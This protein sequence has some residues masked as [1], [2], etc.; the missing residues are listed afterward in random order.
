[1]ALQKEIVLKNGVTTNYHRIV[2]L[3]LITNWSIIIEVRSYVSKDGREIEQRYEELQKK[4][5]K[6]EEL[7]L[8]EQKIYNEGAHCFM[9]SEYFETEYN[10]NTSISALYQYLKTLDKFQDAIDV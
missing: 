7:T 9:Y 6:G 4:M 5:L 1:M 10:E 2:S 8:E 3:N